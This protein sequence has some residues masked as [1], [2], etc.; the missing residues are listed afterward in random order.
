MA[1]KIVIFSGM[2]QVKF[3]L[4]IE[5]VQNNTSVFKLEVCS[6]YSSYN[7]ECTLIGTIFFFFF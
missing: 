2:A 5:V 6:P 4:K 1:K 3:E 7:Y